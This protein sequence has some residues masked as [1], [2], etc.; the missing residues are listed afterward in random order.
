MMSRMPWTTSSPPTTRILH[1]LVAGFDLALLQNTEI[2]TVSPMR[3]QQRRYLRLAH[4]DAHPVTGDARLC[5]FERSAADPVTIA[6]AHLLVGQ[7][8]NGEV[9]SELSIGEIVST[10]LALPIVIGVDLIDED[11]PVLAAVPSQVPLSV[12]VDIESPYQAPALNRCFPNGGVDGLPSPGDI[13]RQTH[14]D[15]TKRAVTFSSRADGFVRPI[16]S[17]K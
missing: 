1:D 9:F 13:T 15:E 10:E 3:D 14:V 17:T 12:A 4:A 5:H 8:F 2:E 11:G 6:N 16:R 7:A